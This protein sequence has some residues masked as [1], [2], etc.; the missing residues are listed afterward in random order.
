MRGSKQK[1]LAWGSYFAMMQDEDVN[2]RY[3]KNLNNTC[4]I[5][6][7]ETENTKCKNDADLR[8]SITHINFAMYLLVNPSP[9]RAMTF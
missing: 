3:Q 9:Y 5:D 6:P 2:K 1:Q 8:I 4:G 7:Y